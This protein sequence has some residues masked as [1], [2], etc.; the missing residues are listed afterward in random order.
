[1]RSRGRRQKQRLR[2][3]ALTLRRARLCKCANGL[4]RE[5]LGT[6]SAWHVL[7]LREVERLRPSETALGEPLERRFDAL[8]ILQ[9]AE[10]NEDRPLDALQGAGDHPGAASWTEVPV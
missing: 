1:S 8:G 7:E 6:Y 5:R 3:R 10:R 2:S 4:D 9:T